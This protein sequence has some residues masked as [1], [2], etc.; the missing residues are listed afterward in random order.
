MKKRIE[1]KEENYDPNEPIRLN[2]Y[3]ANAGVCSRREADEYIQAGV[4]TVNGNVVTELGT[5]VLRTDEVKFHDQPVSLEKKVYVLL[6]KPKDY[7][8]TSDDPQQRKTV[9]DLVKDACPER[10]YPVGRLDRNTT[11]VLLLTNDGDMASKL[12]HPKFLKK[13][14]YHVYLDKN[15]TMHDMQQITEGI[16]LEDGGCVMS[17]KLANNMKLS[18]GDEFK[19]KD[20]NDNIISFKLT[21]ICENYLYNYV[22]ITPQYYNECFGESVKYN[23]VHTIFNYTTQEEQDGLAKT[24]LEDSE[25]VAVNYTDSGVENF[26]KMLS[27]LNM[28]VYVLIISAGALA[29]VV[30]YNLT[31]INIAERAR[32]IATIKVLGFYNGEVGGYIYRENVI[33]TV[34]GALS[35]LVLGIFL[36]GFIIQTVEVDIVMFGRD[37][38]PQSFLYALGLTFLFALIVNFF[39]YF[40][41]KKIDM[42][43]SL[44]SIE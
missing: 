21:A 25:I 1:Y 36:T 33:L 7:V 8:T 24:L 41:M 35:G 40:K 20:I 18:V 27:T 17:E 29:F 14:V 39:M 9:M 38:M 6:N 22:Y 37:I 11:G 42:V 3:L 28:V 12:T 5:K 10:I 15:V 44:K 26:R 2:K 31:N 32:E 4:I 43:E 30:L 23:M 19:I 16:E 34:I 13:K